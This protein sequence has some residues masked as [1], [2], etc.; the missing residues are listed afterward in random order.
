MDIKPLN[1]T[2]SA[3]VLENTP[4]VLSVGLRCMAYGCSFHWHC[5]QVPYLVT[6]DD[7]QVGCVVENN[8]PILPTTH[9]FPKGFA[10]LAPKTRLE[11]ALSR[12]NEPPASGCNAPASGGGLMMIPPVGATPPQAGSL[13]Q[14]PQL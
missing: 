10:V 13:S 8:V 1:E 2:S 6:P 11:E 14:K 3:L 9:E 7:F 12:P 5:G 4:N